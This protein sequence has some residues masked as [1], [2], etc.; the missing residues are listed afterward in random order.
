MRFPRSCQIPSLDP[1]ALALLGTCLLGFCFQVSHLSVDFSPLLPGSQSPLLDDT[2][3][4]TLVK[5]QVPLDCVLYRYGSFSLTMDIVRESCLPWGLAEG[6]VGCL[7]LPVEAYCGRS[8][9][10]GQEYLNPRV[11][12]RRHGD[13]IREAV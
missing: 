2:A 4:L 3:T 6:G 12:I 5:R 13:G 11:F 7:R 10:H 1:V 8:C 9:S